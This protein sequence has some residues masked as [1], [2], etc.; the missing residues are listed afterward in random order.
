MP[1]LIGLQDNAATHLVHL[2]I[3]PISAKKRREF[4]AVK[5]AGDFHASTSWR[6]K[7]RRTRAGAGWSK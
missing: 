5:I 2:G 7:C 6:T 1:R 3:T 4:A